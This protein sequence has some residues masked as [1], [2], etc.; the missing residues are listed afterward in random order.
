MNRTT[1]SIVTFNASFSLGASERQYP[2]GSYRIETDEERLE[3][4]SFHA[5]R[6]T[7]VRVHIPEGLV[8]KGTSITV[9]VTPKQLDDAVANDTA[10]LKLV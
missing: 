6:R 8:R 2:A 9:S 4:L 5:Y 1:T 10:A 3:G 7:T